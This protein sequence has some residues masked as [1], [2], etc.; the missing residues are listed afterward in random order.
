MRRRTTKAKPQ[1]SRL[2]F[3]E[4]LRGLAA[5]YVVIGHICFLADPARLLG[6]TDHAPAAL[7]ALMRPFQFGHL[8][9]ASFIVLSGFCLQLA[10]FARSDGRLTKRKDFYLRRARRILPA[11]YACL[12]FSILVCLNISAHEPTLQRF[13]PVTTPN[14]LAHIFLVHN[15]RLD[16]MY[17][18]NGV[19]WSIAVEVQLYMLFP[20][21][22]RGVRQKGRFVTFTVSSLIA[23]LAMSNVPYAQKLYFWYLPL[24]AAGIIACSLI[25]RPAIR[26]VF[27]KIFAW[28][29]LVGGIWAATQYAT[30]GDPLP[31]GDISIGLAVAALCYLLTSGGAPTLRKII[32]CRPLA[33]LGTF[34]YSLYLMHHPILQIVYSLRP[35]K[36]EEGVFRYLVWVGLPVVLLFTY[37]F[38]QI[39]EIPFMSKRRGWNARPR[40]VPT[41]L[42]LLTYTGSSSRTSEE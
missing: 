8:A 35:L 36:S 26:P 15:W 25:Y 29:T 6:H 38:A 40:R 1:A 14:V 34:S 9:V 21:L 13:L 28:F 39:F 11:Y 23:F 27:Q 42:P 18:I 41:T 20:L 37:G 2:P 7:Q 22:I 24:F 4:G 32:G 30:H 16:W 10:L 5:L 19:L 17:K 12:F 31:N 3:L 33:A